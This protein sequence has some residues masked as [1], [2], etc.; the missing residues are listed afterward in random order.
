MFAVINSI[1][2]PLSEE[3]GLVRRFGENY[4]IYKQNVPRWIPRWKAWDGESGQS[5]HSN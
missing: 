2:I 5:G 4:V 1:Y 3:P